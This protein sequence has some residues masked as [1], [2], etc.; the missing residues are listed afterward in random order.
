[1]PAC[2]RS[3]NHGQDARLDRLARHHLS[4]RAPSRHYRWI[5]HRN[6][7]R[8]FPPDRFHSGLVSPACPPDR[9]LTFIRAQLNVGRLVF[10]HCNAHRRLGCAWTASICF[11]GSSLYKTFLMSPLVLPTVVTGVALLQF[12]YLIRLDTSLLGLLAAHVLITIPYVLRTVGAGL[13]GLDPEIE[14]AAASLGSGERRTLLRVTLP[15]IAPSIMA[16]VIFVFITSFDQTTVSIFLADV[17]LKPLPVL[18]F[19]Y[20]DLAVDP[21]IAAVSTLL[22]N[23]L[24]A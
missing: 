10:A 1:M 17:D 16:A 2:S 19:N 7:L 23:S 6:P 5:I 12:Y 18:I 11:E 13:V 20:I 21:M 4:D 3:I 14:E 15:A 24:L 9:L 22:I 8:R